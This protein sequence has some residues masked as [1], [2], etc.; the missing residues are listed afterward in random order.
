M[1]EGHVRE[2]ELGE[3]QDVAGDLAAGESS[4]MECGADIWEML[5]MFRVGFANPALTQPG[6]WSAFGTG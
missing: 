4:L 6:G 3:C 2:F 5:F 1:G